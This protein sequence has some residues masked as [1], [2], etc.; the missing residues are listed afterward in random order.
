MMN[1]KGCG[2][3]RSLS[4][5][6]HHS[7]ICVQGKGKKVVLCGTSRRVTGLEV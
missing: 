3:T 1:S 2:R 5:C 4:N 6:K 7:D